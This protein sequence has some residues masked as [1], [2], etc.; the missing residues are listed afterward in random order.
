MGWPLPTCPESISGSASVSP[1]APEVSQPPHKALKQFVLDNPDRFGAA[2]DASVWRATTEYALRSGD[3]IDVFFKSDRCWIGV[4]V[5]SSISDSTP[6]DYERGIYQ[7][8]KYLA[9]LTA[10]AKIDHP[11]APPSVAV[12]LALEST[13]PFQL[14]ATARDLGVRVIEGLGTAQG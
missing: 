2:R 7:V 13:L 11:A 9:L 8:V 3:Q 6:D 4:E 12:V 5:K 1:V 14:H 10:Q